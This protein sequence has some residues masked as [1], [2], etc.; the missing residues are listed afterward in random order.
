[1]EPGTV[2]TY[3]ISINS[4]NKLENTEAIRYS[5]FLSRTDLITFQKIQNSKA[6]E[7]LHGILRNVNKPNSKPQT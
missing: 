1:M 5:H 7:L 3:C 6:L 4:K 2:T